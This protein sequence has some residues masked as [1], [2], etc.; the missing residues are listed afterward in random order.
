MKAASQLVSACITKVSVIVC[1]STVR[2]KKLL[3]V[4][5]N[6]KLIEIY[7]GDIIT[8]LLSLVWEK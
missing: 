6:N 4:Q 2:A 3:N 1:N 8:Q 5:M 7:D